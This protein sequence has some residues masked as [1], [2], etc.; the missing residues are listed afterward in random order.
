MQ[1]EQIEKTYFYNGKKN[2]YMSEVRRAHLKRTHM[3]KK[4]TR[5][6]CPKHYEVVC[7]RLLD[8]LL[9]KMPF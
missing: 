6:V 3:V 2:V 5:E 7:N 1:K 4:K 8:Y 9:T